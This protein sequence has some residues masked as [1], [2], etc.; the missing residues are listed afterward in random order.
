MNN[1]ELSRIQTFFK[2]INIFMNVFQHFN[3]ITSQRFEAF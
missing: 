3:N 2:K 1:L